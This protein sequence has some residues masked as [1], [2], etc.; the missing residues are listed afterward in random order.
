LC[1]PDYKKMYQVGSVAQG[2]RL[3][4]NRVIITNSSRTFT[5]PENGY[6]F[7]KS[8]ID[9]G[10]YDFYIDGIRFRHVGVSE[11]WDMIDEYEIYPIAKGSTAMIGDTTN[12]N[13]IHVIMYFAPIVK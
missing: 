10:Y 1:F 7:L 3:D 13:N 6:I 8:S 11:L 4:D 5:A 9:D 12:I 2:S